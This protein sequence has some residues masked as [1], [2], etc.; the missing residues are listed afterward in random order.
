MFGKGYNYN[1]HVLLNLHTLN[2]TSKLETPSSVYMYI[3][4]NDYAT[5]INNVYYNG[6][7]SNQTL[8]EILEKVTL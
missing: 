5:K 1:S 2:T 7:C 4:P 8:S 3:F 6:S